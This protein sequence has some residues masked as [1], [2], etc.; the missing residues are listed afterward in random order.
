MKLVFTGN[1]HAN[2][3]RSYAP[4]IVYFPKVNIVQITNFDD[5]GLYL[6]AKPYNLL[7]YFW[8]LRGKIAD[9]FCI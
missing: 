7:V 2:A 8:G 3:K 4:G 6:I 9:D 5:E 1:H